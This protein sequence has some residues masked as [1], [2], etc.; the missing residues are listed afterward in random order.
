VDALTAISSKRAIRKFAERPLDDEDLNRILDA[1]RRAA[2]SK[3]TQRW[4][5]VVV[6]DRER[7]KRLAKVGPW[8]GHLAGAAAGIALVTPTGEDGDDPPSVMFD[9]G[10]AAAQMMVA[11]WALGV[12]TCP[13]TAYEPERAAEILGLPK[14]QRCRYLISAGYPANPDDLTRAP[15]SGGRRLLAD[16]IRGETW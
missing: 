13:V 10:Q 3:N 6:R 16:V 11:A 12:G 4:T 1:G 9:L 2:S 5:F 8:A 7:L 15:K 14:G